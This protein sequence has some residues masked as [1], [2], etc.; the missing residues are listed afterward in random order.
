MK[1][2][3]PRIATLVATFTALILAIAKVIVGFM[4]GSVAVIASALDSILDMAVSIFNNIALKISE[5]SPNS[6]YPYG[7]GKIEGLAALFEGLIITGSG[8]FIIYEAVR[9]ILQKETISNFDIS[10]YV[11]IFSIIV[12]AALVSFLL[13]V[14]KKTNNIVIKSDALHYKTDL[15]VNA[16]VLVS[17]II[18]K[19]TGLYWIDY[20]LSIAIGIYIIKEASEI[21]KEGFEILLDAALDFETIEKIKE[22][23]KKEPLVLDYHCLR[24]R[25]AGIRNFVDVHLVMTPDMKLKLAHSIVEN[26]EEKIRNIDKNKKWIIN[27]HADPY[28]DSLVNK[29][30]EE[31]D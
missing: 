21:I 9:K 2:S 25:K 4:S 23:L 10:I 30:Q 18:V 24:T 15:V 19:F 28:D 22:I 27:I 8:V 3:L 26:V 17:L 6:K 12:T 5:S 29:M 11:M 16:S 1:L 7:K 31:C 14:Y 13:Y 20:V